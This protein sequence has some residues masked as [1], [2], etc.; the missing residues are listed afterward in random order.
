M[1]TKP[2]DRLMFT[3]GGLCFF[4]KK[5]LS[6][7][8]ASVEHLVASANGGNNHHDNCVVCCEAL[9]SLFGSMSLKEKIQVILNQRGQ[10][11]CP[12][13]SGP[14]KSASRASRSLSEK[15]ELIIADLHKRGAARPRTVKTLASTISALFQKHLPGAEVSSLVEELRARGVVIIDGAKVTYALPPKVA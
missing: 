8:E 3:Q 7:S 9:N 12:G 2:L 5:P 15:L 10:F 11:V 1:A 6:E 14:S 13:S 4:C